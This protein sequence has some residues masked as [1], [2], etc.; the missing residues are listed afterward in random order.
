MR[1]VWVVHKF[2]YFSGCGGAL[3]PMM[4]MMMSMQTTHAAPYLKRT[5]AID[6]NFASVWPLQA[7]F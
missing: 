7:V 5:M 2:S 1:W 6:K 3:C 4:S